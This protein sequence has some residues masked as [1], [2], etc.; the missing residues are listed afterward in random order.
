MVPFSS[1]IL[2]AF[3]YVDEV[4]DIH[5][6]HCMSQAKFGVTD[7]DA[8]QRLFRLIKR[9]NADDM[10]HDCMESSL[11]CASVPAISTARNS[12]LNANGGG[13]PDDVASLDCL[14]AMNNLLDLDALDINDSFLTGVRFFLCCPSLSP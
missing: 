14:R 12:E 11:D 2:F 5:L 9:I 13:D 7:L 4:L 8:K 1:E 10:S 6:Y 3:E